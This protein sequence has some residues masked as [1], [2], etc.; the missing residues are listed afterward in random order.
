LFVAGEP[1][2]VPE[3]AAAAEVD[4]QS[5]PGALAELERRLAERGAGVVLDRAGARYGL[6]AA[7]GGP[8]EAASRLQARA[9]ERGLSPAA[10]ETLAVVAYLQPIGRPEIARIRGPRRRRRRGP[11][12]TAADRG[13][14]PRRWLGMPVL[15]RT[16][17]IFERI[18][19]A[20][21]GARGPARIDAGA[22]NRGALPAKGSTR[23]PPSAAESRLRMS[24][25]TGTG[26]ASVA[27]TSEAPPNRYLA[28]SDWNR[29]A[30]WRRSS[31][32]G[33]SRSTASLPPRPGSAS[34]R[35]ARHARQESRRTR[36]ARLRAAAKPADVVTT[37]RD[38]HGR[39]TVV[40]L[41][42][43]DRRLFP[44]GARCR[45]DGLLTSNDGDLAARL[46]HPRHGVGKT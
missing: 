33:A 15:Y 44:V 16:T 25:W 29:D 27:M 38:T 26:H 23:S 32:T 3:I 13:G 19:G 37:V 39:R 36:P 4:E 2:T 21:G 40:D 8:A 35:S 43:A 46:M 22:A 31:R 18:F 42:G 7:P 41:V 11:A 30:A 20:R 12:R 1:L 10:L 14:R 17:T 24:A 6:R 45:H 34:R 28:A 5:V 9:P